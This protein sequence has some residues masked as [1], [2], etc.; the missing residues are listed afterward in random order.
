MNDQEERKGPANAE[1]Q[2]EHKMPREEFNELIQRQN[3]I[4]TQVMRNAPDFMVDEAYN[5]HE[6]A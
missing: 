6:R 1:P 5:K 3:E 2:E 4:N